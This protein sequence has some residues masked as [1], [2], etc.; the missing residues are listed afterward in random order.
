MTVAT[1]GG[2]AADTTTPSIEH[3]SVEVAPVSV[4]ATWDAGA[5]HPTT[6]MDARAK[7]MISNAFMLIELRAVATL[8][9]VDNEL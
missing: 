7:P 5:L 8:S 1:S 3:A 6:V 4:H 9:V 2:I